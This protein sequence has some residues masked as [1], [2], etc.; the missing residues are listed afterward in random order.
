MRAQSLSCVR[1]FEITWT[2]AQEAC[3]SVGFPRQGYWSGLLFLTP[4]DLPDP[5]IEHTSPVWQADPLPMSHQGNQWSSQLPPN[6]LGAASRLMPFFMALIWSIY[7]INPSGAFSWKTSIW[8]KL[9]F[10]KIY[11]KNSF[12]PSR[13][14]ERQGTE[15]W[16]LIPHTSWPLVHWTF[17]EKT[18]RRASFSSYHPLGRIIG[19]EM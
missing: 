19:S 13:I 2:I 15:C 8:D 18:L 9:V 10:S 5:G 7:S 16:S 12:F 4:R 17:I 3:L 6:P 1:L 14:L 11:F